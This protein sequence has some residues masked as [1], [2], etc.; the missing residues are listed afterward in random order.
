MDYKGTKP[1]DG[2]SSFP[3]QAGGFTDRADSPIMT[4]VHLIQKVLHETPGQEK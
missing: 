3:N 4:I 2:R 1:L